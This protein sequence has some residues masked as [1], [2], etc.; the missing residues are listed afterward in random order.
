MNAS[1]FAWR[2]ANPVIVLA[3]LSGLFQGLT[4]CGFSK[5]R[6]EPDYKMNFRSYRN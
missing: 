6:M 1:S 3:F 4:L 5:N 2:K